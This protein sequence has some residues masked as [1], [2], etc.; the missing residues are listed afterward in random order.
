VGSLYPIIQKK[1]KKKKPSKH[2]S[3]CFFGAL[4]NM[5]S[6]LILSV[7]SFQFK[8]LKGKAMSFRVILHDS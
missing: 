2:T 4:E 5:P 8:F 1:K 7:L 6:L 3:L